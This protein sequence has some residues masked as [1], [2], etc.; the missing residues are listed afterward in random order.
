M[1][2]VVFFTSH[3]KWSWIM[4][5][6]GYLTY[7]YWK[8]DISD[9]L[10]M[11]GDC[12]FLNCMEY[13]LRGGGPK[14]TEDCSDR[15]SLAYYAEVFQIFGETTLV[16]YSL[17]FANNEEHERAL[18]FPH[19]QLLRAANYV[20]SDESLPF[21]EGGFWYV[22]VMVPICIANG[23]AALITFAY[24]FAFWKGWCSK[25]KE[26]PCWVAKAATEAAADQVGAVSAEIAKTVSSTEVRSSDPPACLRTRI[27]PLTYTFVPAESLRGPEPSIS[28]NFAWLV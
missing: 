22:V 11:G 3:P 20:R 18:P 27:A 24:V 9:A 12:A 1:V 4:M 2:V 8:I 16:L 14:P 19:R 10:E 21:A 17:Y 13:R 5:C 23:V 28:S 25:C 26:N 7:F 6:I 15:G